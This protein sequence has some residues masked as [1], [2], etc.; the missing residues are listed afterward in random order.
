[1]LTKQTPETISASLKIKAMGK[2]YSLMLTY[3]NHK[4]ED[5]DAWRQNPENIQL[6]ESAKSSEIEM[7]RSMNASV[8][9]FVIKSFD[10]GT[11]EAFP[12]NYAG[13][14]DMDRTWPG[15]L[16]GI[17]VGYHQARAASVEKN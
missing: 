2:E 13:L 14:I 11:D 5:F 17:L 4:L 8:A 3:T 6:P 1:M 12:L 16:N 10:D 15:I 7:I 9:L